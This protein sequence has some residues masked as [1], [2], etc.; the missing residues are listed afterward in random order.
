[1]HYTVAAGLSAAA[2]QAGPAVGEA[3]RGPHPD[4]PRYHLRPLAV[5]QDPQAPGRPRAGVCQLRCFPEA[6]IPG[7]KDEVR[8]DPAEVEPSAASSRP[9]RDQSQH[10]RRGAQAHREQE[11]SM[12]RHRC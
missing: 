11:D 12:L 10:Q 8:R 6:D 2:V 4:P 7:G 9:N 3:P 5:H 1:M